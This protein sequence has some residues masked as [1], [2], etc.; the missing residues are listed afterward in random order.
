MGYSR[1]VRCAE[2]HCRSPRSLYSGRHCTAGDERKNA[3]RDPP[4]ILINTWSHLFSSPIT[5]PNADRFLPTGKEFGRRS[6]ASTPG[7]TTSSDCQ[8]ETCASPA[9]I[10]G[11][12]ESVDFNLLQRENCYSSVE[13]S[14]A[15]FAF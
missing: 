8:A 12:T 7:H 10:Q 11:R 5:K 9:Q 4:V 2:A 3:P 6:F 15:A 1:C 13:S 14:R